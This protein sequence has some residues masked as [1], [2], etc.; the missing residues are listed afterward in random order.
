MPIMGMLL[1]LVACVLIVALITEAW[2]GD[3]KPHTHDHKVPALAWV[4]PPMPDALF[5]P[6]GRGIDTNDIV[7]AHYR[8]RDRDHWAAI[9][10]SANMQNNAALWTSVLTLPVS[11]P[12]A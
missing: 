7:M 10:A 1:P 6:S 8:Q 9:N 4:P 3:S 5:L 2:S 11:N 12:S